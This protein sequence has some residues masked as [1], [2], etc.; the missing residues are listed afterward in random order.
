MSARAA[1]RLN[2]VRLA[3]LQTPH[4]LVA[5]ARAVSRDDWTAVV[6][7]ILGVAIIIVALLR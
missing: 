6:C 2:A 4:V 7:G 3:A 1:R 5:E